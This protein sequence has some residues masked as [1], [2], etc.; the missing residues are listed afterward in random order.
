MER[1]GKVSG[2]RF[3]YLKAKCHRYGFDSTLLELKQRLHTNRS[4][5]M[6][7]EAYGSNF[8][9]ILAMSSTSAERD[10]FMIAT[11]EHPMAAMLMNET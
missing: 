7:R 6:K 3:F 8:T 4:T 5:M 2:A 11:S 9:Y 10:L 1:A